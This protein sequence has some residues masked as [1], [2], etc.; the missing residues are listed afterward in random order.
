M[1]IP[2]RLYERIST[3]NRQFRS[4]GVSLT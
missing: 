1:D 2:L 4:N 3:E